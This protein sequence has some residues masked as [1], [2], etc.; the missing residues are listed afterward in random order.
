MP[1]RVHDFIT[2][3]INQMDSHQVKFD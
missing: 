2:M 1:V 3:I